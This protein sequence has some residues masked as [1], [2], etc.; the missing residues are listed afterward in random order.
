MFRPT[1]H[2]E[3]RVQLHLL[4]RVEKE[5]ETLNED[6]QIIRWEK[7]SD[8]YFISPMEIKVRK[9]RKVSK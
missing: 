6:K 4:E 8:E 3:R 7:C 2:L 1:Q 5:L 9:K